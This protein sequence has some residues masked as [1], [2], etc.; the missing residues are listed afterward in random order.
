MNNNLLVWNYEYHEIRTVEK[1]SE[2]WFVAKDVAK[3]LGYANASKAIADHV[4]AEDKGVTK[5]YTLG[6]A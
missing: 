5:C 4:D 3:V 2:P 6:G 1:D